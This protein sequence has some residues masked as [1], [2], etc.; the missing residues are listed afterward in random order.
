MYH[1]LKHLER[2]FICYHSEFVIDTKSFGYLFQSLLDF[3]LQI[4]YQIQNEE[5]NFHFAIFDM[6]KEYTGCVERQT[7]YVAKSFKQQFW[8]QQ[9]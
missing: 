8:Q 2:L 5:E 1:E 4:D 7:E 3:K 6:F 9:D